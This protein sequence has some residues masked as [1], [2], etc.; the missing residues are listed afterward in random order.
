[1]LPGEQCH[2]VQWTIKGLRFD[3]K[4]LQLTHGS[5][6]MPPGKSIAS[7][8][9]R[10][11]GVCGYFRFWPNGFLSNSQRRRADGHDLGG[12]VGN[13]WCCLGVFLP[14]GS[15]LRVRFF[16][17]EAKSQ[18]KTVYWNQGTNVQQLWTPT[19][20]QPPNFDDLSDFPVGIEIAANYREDNVNKRSPVTSPRRH[21]IPMLR[22]DHDW[23]SP[24][25][26]P[27]SVRLLKPEPLTLPAITGSLT[28]KGMFLFQVPTM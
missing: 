12:L 2:R 24:Q 15:H 28:Q 18:F 7:P 10:A 17:G 6:E 1:M 3:R 13:S 9:F 11:G 16:C 22:S 14:G 26:S 5:V 23:S 27:R 8:P 21:K 20:T 19:A 25:S 4:L